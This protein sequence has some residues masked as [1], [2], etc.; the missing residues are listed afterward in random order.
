[1]MTASGSA[2]RIIKELKHG[3]A[4]GTTVF[5][6]GLP[7]AI[8]PALWADICTYAG[9]EVPNYFKAMSS[10]VDYSFVEYWYF[11]SGDT[12][13]KIILHLI[14]QHLIEYYERH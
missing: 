13:Q 7:S 9:Q 8:L 12:V 11:T 1:M 2:A 3:K 14:D 5:F 4:C 6:A 10:P